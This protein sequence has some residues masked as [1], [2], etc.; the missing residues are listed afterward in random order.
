ML[1]QLNQL[2]YLELLEIRET[3]EWEFRLL[4][5]EAVVIDNAPAITEK[6]EPNEE[7]RELLKDTKS[8]R[9]T[10]SSRR[11]EIIFTD[12]ISYSVTNESYSIPGE[13]EEFIGKYARIYTK[14]AFLDYISKSTFA[15]AEYPGPFKH[16]CFCC[17][18]HII[19]IAS[20]EEPRV[21]LLNA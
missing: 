19:N 15:T 4:I 2:Q 6:E 7:I 14:S 11:Y 1:E 12:Y 13:N 20:L 3:N 8:I 16:Y 17:Q 5:A 10:S 21:R 18:D 9:V